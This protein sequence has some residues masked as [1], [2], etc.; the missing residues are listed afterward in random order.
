MEEYRLKSIIKFT[1]IK[2]IFYAY[3]LD[4]FKGQ[5]KFSKNK[6][7]YFYIPTKEL[8]K[9]K[10]NNIENFINKFTNKKY[11][12]MMHYEGLVDV[13]YI[14]ED[15]FDTGNSVF[16][17]KCHLVSLKTNDYYKELEKYNSFN[18]LDDKNKLI[19]VS[20]I[21]LFTATILRTYYNE[22]WQNVEKYFDY[23]IKYF[24]FQEAI[25]CAYITNFATR[26]VSYN[27]GINALPLIFED[28][29]K[30]ITYMN[31]HQK[32]SIFVTNLKEHEKV[33]FE[34]H[35]DEESY[36]I[37]KKRKLFEHDEIALLGLK[38]IFEEKIKRYK[39]A[40]KKL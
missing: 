8:S 31:F 29:D 38:N 39:T 20:R 16:N 24:D 23:F 22:R 7:I 11:F 10:N 37:Q 27:F 36:M 34:N 17:K 6:R 25:T 15:Y 21:M 28:I 13:D 3:C 5:V 19:I 40:I 26:D 18:I 1:G 4:R 30:W 2:K 32:Y 9:E 35:H 33:H 12:Y 14:Q